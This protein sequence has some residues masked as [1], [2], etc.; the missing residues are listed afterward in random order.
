MCWPNGCEQNKQACCALSSICFPQQSAMWQIVVA[1]PF[2]A[3]IILYETPYHKGRFII[4]S[5]VDVVN[6]QIFFWSDR[7]SFAKKSAFD[8]KFRLSS[9]AVSNFSI[10]SSQ[11]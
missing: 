1:R 5:R 3:L 2:I 6:F 8:L 9:K 11:Q 10:N 4:F 7:L